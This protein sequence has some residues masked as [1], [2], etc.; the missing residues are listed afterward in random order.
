MIILASKSERRIELLKKLTQ[1]FKVV[2][3]EVKED[4]GFKDAA[5]LVLRL[6]LLKAESIVS[7]YPVIG[8]DTV[9]SIEGSVFGKPKDAGQAL[10]ILKCLSGKTHEVMTGIC[11]A[12]KNMRMLFFEKTKVTFNKLTEPELKDYIER[13]KPYDKAGSYGIQDNFNLVSKIDGDYDNVLGLPITTLRK[14]LQ[15]FEKLTEEKW[16]TLNLQSI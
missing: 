3:P 15:D 9:V 1:D 13:F 10:E 5:S 6:S 11:I 8:S 7:N 14:K 16:L 4:I 12:Y 2:P